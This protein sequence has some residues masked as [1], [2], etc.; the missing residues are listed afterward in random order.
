[1]SA[2]IIILKCRIH[3]DDKQYNPENETE[4][5]KVLSSQFSFLLLEH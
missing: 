5:R 4:T 2:H 1:M 3:K